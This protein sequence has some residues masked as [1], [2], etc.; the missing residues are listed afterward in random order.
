MNSIEMLTQ[1]RV[2]VADL[3][4]TNTGNRVAFRR[5]HSTM[6]SCGK[7]RLVARSFELVRIIYLAQWILRIRTRPG[8]GKWGVGR[9]AHLLSRL[10][11]ILMSGLGLILTSPRPFPLAFEYSRTCNYRSSNLDRHLTSP[12]HAYEDSSQIF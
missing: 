9:G 7:E 10:W 11:N 3:L 6:S 5:A 2:K 1:F 8:R 4:E 12:I